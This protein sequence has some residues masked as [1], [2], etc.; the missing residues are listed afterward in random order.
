MVCDSIVLNST[1]VEA[2]CK[3]MATARQRRRRRRGPMS[4][5]DESR[6]FLPLSPSPSNACTGPMG[7]GE[8]RMGDALSAKG[9]V[10][11]GLLRPLLSP[12]MDADVCRSEAVEEQA[13]M[14][15]HVNAV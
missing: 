12:T 1:R 4:K 8:R 5:R 14:K 13:G 6:P 7:K 11:P 3:N 15:L 2:T 9:R 10:A